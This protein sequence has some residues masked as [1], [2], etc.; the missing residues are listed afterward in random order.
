MIG[1]IV[2]FATPRDLCRVYDRLAV[3]YAITKKMGQG[4]VKN[5]VAANCPLAF[6]Q[7]TFFFSFMPASSKTESGNSKC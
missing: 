7:L 3:N 4:D 2:S 6:C 1:R 5:F